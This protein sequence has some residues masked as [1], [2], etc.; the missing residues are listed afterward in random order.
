MTRQVSPKGHVKEAVGPTVGHDSD[1]PAFDVLMVI[2]PGSEL[3]AP[4]PGSAL[5]VKYVA[6]RRPS[7]SS[8]LADGSP[9]APMALTSREK[10]G[11]SPRISEYTIRVSTRCPIAFEYD[12]TGHPT[13]T[14]A[15]PT[16]RPIDY[17]NI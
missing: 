13:R 1:G 15:P 5:T 12:R 4:A 3:P 14:A 8:L 2:S 6:S 17:V 16:G 9:K 11:L 7:P 10:N